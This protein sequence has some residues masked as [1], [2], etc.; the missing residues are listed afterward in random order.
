MNAPFFQYITIDVKTCKN[1]T[2]DRGCIL[3]F[4]FKMFFL[5]YHSPLKKK[6]KPGLHSEMGDSRAEARKIQQGVSVL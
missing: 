3:Q 2:A 1:M 4:Q 6:K 5:E